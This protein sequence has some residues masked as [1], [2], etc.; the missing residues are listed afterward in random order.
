MNVYE[1]TIFMPCGK[2][3]HIEITANN[4][5]MAVRSLMCWYSCGTIFFVRGK[6]YK[7]IKSDNSISG[8]VDLAKI[9]FV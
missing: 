8:Y 4:E 1:I 9:N 6:F 5:E 2:I 3:K 7:I